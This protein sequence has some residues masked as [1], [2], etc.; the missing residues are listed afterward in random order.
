MRN[1]ELLHLEPKWPLK[2]PRER[3][4]FLFFHFKMIRIFF[5][6][7]S[8]CTLRCLTLNVIPVTYGRVINYPKT[9][10]LKTKH[11]TIFHDS[12]GQKSKQGSAIKFFCSP[13]S[14]LGSFGGIQLMGWYRSPKWIHSHACLSTDWWK[15]G[16]NYALPSLHAVSGP[17]HMVPPAELLTWRLKIP[18]VNIRDTGNG[19]V[20]LLRVGPRI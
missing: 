17:L 20:S 15:T 13:W 4:V 11:F 18:K 6:Y 10:W 7:P 5:P 8:C 19:N 2:R 9:K 16:F 14:W 3:A 1:R 12:V